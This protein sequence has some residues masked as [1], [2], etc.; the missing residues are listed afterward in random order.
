MNAIIV[1][2]SHPLPAA[3]S[4]AA[5]ATTSATTRETA[6]A[7]ATTG[8]LTAKSSRGALAARK[9]PVR[10]HPGIPTAPHTL[11]RPSA[12]TLLET[13]LQGG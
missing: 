10:T 3:S 6:L 1:I 11:E 9:T 4:S 7:P 13:L 8:P 5:T 12:P 2:G